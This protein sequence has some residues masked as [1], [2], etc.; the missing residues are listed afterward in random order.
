MRRGIWHQFGDRSQT[1]ALEQLEQGV[2]VGVIVSPRDLALHKAVEYAEQYHHLGAQVLIDCQFYVPDF[3]NDKITSY[4][5]DEYRAPV[6]QLHQ[7]TDQQ[8]AGLALTLEDRHRELSA[9]GIIAPA[10]V[11]EAGRPD[12][13]DINAQLFNTAKKSW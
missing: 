1:L 11:Y 7:V 4:E 9:D 8:L 10:I 2:G 13:V 6:S 3:S 5:M 12:I